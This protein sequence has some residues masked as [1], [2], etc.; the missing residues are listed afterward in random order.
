MADFS[1]EYDE[2]VGFGIHDF[3]IEQE[4]NKLKKNHYVSVICEGFGIVG[5]GKDED[6]KMKVAL[7]IDRAVSLGLIIDS[8][9]IDYIWVDYDKFLEAFKKKDL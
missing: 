7:H 6:S 4:F 1:K 3:S 8:I 5:I 2:L 9:D